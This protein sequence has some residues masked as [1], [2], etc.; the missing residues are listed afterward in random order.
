[1]IDA[2][3]FAS[4]TLGFVNAPALIQRIV[5]RIQHASVDIGVYRRKRDFLYRELTRIGYEMVKPQGAFYMFPRSPL[6]DDRVFVALL[7][8]KL[9]LVVPGA[10]FGTP[11]YFRLS[12]CVDDHTL[13]GSIPGFEAAWRETH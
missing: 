6:P 5:A 7:Q 4:R 10:G 9:V 2:A 12:Y 8:T 1:L 13:E 11:G 3:T